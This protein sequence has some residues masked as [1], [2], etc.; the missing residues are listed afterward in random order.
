MIGRF[1]TRQGLDSDEH[2]VSISDVMAGLMVIFLFV[3]MSYMLNVHQQTKKIIEHEQTI[4]NIV[5]SYKNLKDKLA[6]DLHSEF[7]GDPNKQRQFESEWQGY[8]NMDTLTTGFKHPFQIG[9]EIVPD[10]FKDLLTAFFP[11][12][13][14]ILAKADYKAEIEEIRIEGHT[15]SEWQDQVSIDAAFINNM[16]LS[17]NRARNVL[18]YVLEIDALQISENKIWLK[19][20]VTANGLSSS[21]LLVDNNLREAANPYS[22]IAEE[23]NIKEYVVQSLHQHLLSEIPD[24]QKNQ[25]IDKAEIVKRSSDYFKIKPEAVERVV[26]LLLEDK[27]ASR[28]VEFRIVT[29]SEKVIEDVKQLVEDFNK[30]RE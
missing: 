22:T 3:A 2:W 4:Q 29:K 1:L 27:K 18:D 8:L 15:S 30:S 25:V 19:K 26:G 7:Q 5:E 23:T 11:R 10:E 28:R 14:A 13:I 12:Y 24:W 21:H 6:Q 17:Q 20:K 9:G 16:E